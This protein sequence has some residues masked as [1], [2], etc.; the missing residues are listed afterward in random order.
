MT[1]NALGIIPIKTD[2]C[3][4]MWNRAKKLGMTVKKGN[5][6]SGDLVFYDFNG[7]GTPD[8][9]GIVVQVTK[10][11]IWAVEGNTGSGSNTNGGQVQKRK[12]SDHILGYARPKY[13]K[14]VTANMVVATALAEV[15][16]KE[17]PKNS[18]KVKYNVWYYKKNIS[19]YWCCTF[20]CWCFGNVI[21]VKAVAKPSG[22][23]SVK[24][25]NKLVKRGSKGDHVVQ[26]Q[27]FLNWYHPDWK[28]AEDGECGK[29]TEAAIMSY[30]LTEGL[31]VDGEFGPKSRERANTYMAKKETKPAATQATK[32]AAAKNGYTGAFPESN[33]NAKIINGL[34]FRQCWP[35]G[36]KKNKYTYEKG[37]PLKAYTAGIDKA[38]PKH[39]E[40]PNK[41]QRVGACCDVF[42]GECLGNVGIKVPKDLKNQLKQMPKMTDQ[43]KSNGHYKAADFEMADIVQRGRKDYSG[44]TFVIAVVYRVETVTDK[45]TGKKSSKVKGTKHIA[46]SHYK[47]FGGCYAVMDSKA[48]TQKPSSW[49]YYK[50]YTP[51][52]AVRTYYKKG[53]YG[54]D[55]YKIQKFLKW[56]GYYTGALDFDF[57]AK[58]DAAVKAYQK[59]CGLKPDG[60]VGSSTIKAMEAERE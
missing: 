7:N 8:H 56:A 10:N 21:E 6:K 27:K 37:K 38:Y 54:L 33:N 22:T 50:C 34:A 39:K 36:T 29:K 47:K 9:I 31:T 13:T 57:G 46:N 30:Q 25:I 14:T 59:H 35:Y 52:G 17:S 12:R 32:P 24:L 44:H 43:L 20:V 60:R 23:C 1:I 53:D 16:T 45:K 15:G 55:V 49:K 28:L 48:T 26:V 18:N 3:P 41:K 51:L 5:Q 42:V 2:S 40:W 58:T 4:T 19:A 11:Y